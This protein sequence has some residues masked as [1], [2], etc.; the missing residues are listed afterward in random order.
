MAND[1]LINNQSIAKKVVLYLRVSSQEQVDNSSL[2][3]QE[4]GCGDYAL[5]NGYEVD[6]V[7]IEIN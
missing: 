4:R 3:T 6:R 7:F 1:K 2:E 5:R